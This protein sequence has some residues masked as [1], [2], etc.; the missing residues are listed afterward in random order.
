MTLLRT[1]RYLVV[2]PRASD[3]ALY[4]RVYGGLCLAGAETLDLL[5]SCASPRPASDDSR[6]VE[7]RARRLLVEDD[8]ESILDDRSEQRRSDLATGRQIR[9]V[10]LVLTNRC[11]F[12]CSY[13]FEALGDTPIEETI[14]ARSS[15]ER[16]E[17]QSSTAN[18]T[19]SPQ[20]AEEYLRAAIGMAK[21][22]GTR[23]LAVQFFGGEPLVNWR[24]VR[25]VLD[26]FGGGD[27]E[28]SLS[29]SIVTNGSLITDEIA[30]KFR[31][32][33]V[34]VI[35]SYDSPA[36][37]PRPMRNGKSS[38]DA[39]RRGLDLLRRHDNRVALNAALTEATF[40]LFGRDLVD[41]AFDRGVYEIG[42]VLDLDPSFYETRGAASIAAE[43]WDVIAYGASRGVVLTGY[44]HQIFQCLAA[45][46]RYSQIGYQNCSAMGVQ[47]SIEPDGQV[48]A[49]KASGASF[50]SIRDPDALLRSPTYASYAMRACTPP[51][52]C[53]GCDIEHFCAGL[54]LGSIENRY[55][56]IGRIEPAA[57]DAYR[58]L[59]RRYVATVDRSEVAFV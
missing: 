41:F 8:E 7:L 40:D 48:F 11:N 6:I 47:L 18:V 42:V 15:S 21:R 45:F 53:R 5:R 54:C 2:V 50:G 17:A 9:V 4:H 44:W 31:E 23:A 37:D 16:R 34:A 14:Y 52:A 26:R 57:C 13:C 46:D 27:G 25:H 39:V 43:L 36:G 12:R 19:M 29:Y 38:H 49:C 51:P 35:V 28:M 58:D 24:T 56:D 33:G 59:T 30:R 3:F 1:S 22:A 55:G 32:L 10:Q 20:L